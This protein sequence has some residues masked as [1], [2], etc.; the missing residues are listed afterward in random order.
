MTDPAPKQFKKS[1]RKDIHTI[2]ILVANKPGVLSRIA[3]IFARRAYN[4]DSLVVSPT[5]DGHFSRMTITA[6]GELKTLEQIIKQL[7]KLVDVIH[8]S[9][10]KRED[11]IDTEFALIKVRTT[12]ET[13]V[14]ILQCVDHFKGK[15]VDFTD[16]SLVIQVTGSTEKLDAMV[17]MLFKYG[18]L[19]MVRSGKMIMARGGETT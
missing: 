19:E 8:A 1:E 12:N 6:I 5:L 9:E 4:I 2:S 3:T 17:E 7:N 10:H 16:E 14:G 11:V 15:T 13:R 18:V